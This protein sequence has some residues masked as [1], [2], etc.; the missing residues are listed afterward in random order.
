MPAPVG[1]LVAFSTRPGEM[2]RDGG[3]SL[4]VY[5]RH[6]TRTLKEAPQLPIE[7]FF[8]RV[9]AGVAAETNNKQVPW[10]SSD[11]NGE[12]CFRPDAKGNC[13]GGG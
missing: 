1:T 9:R 12:L 6:L 2:A 3:G 13:V 8:K 11:L 7:Q 4:S 5:A 10:E